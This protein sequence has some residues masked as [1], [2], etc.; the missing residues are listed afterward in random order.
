MLLMICRPVVFARQSTADRQGKH[1]LTFSHLIR[2]QMT[3]NPEG[4]RIKTTRQVFDIVEVLKESGGLGV[5]E[6]ARELNMSK[7]NAHRHLTTLDEVGYVVCE[8]GLYHPSARFLDIG[9]YVRYRNP[10][11]ELVQPKVE[12]LAEKTQERAEFI[13]EEHGRGVFL[14]RSTGANA[15]GTNTR[16]GATLPL[17]ASAAG[18]A[19]LSFLPEERLDEIIKQQGLQEQTPHTITDDETLREELE[20]IRETS[21]AY[22]D[23]ELI[24]G[25]RAVGTPICTPDG[26]VL[27]A[28]SITGPT[29]R[30]R[31]D[32]IESELPD[33]LRGVANEV[34]LNLAYS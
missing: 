22:N 2:P 14:H 28:L 34:E 15:V 27:G 16:I 1:S 18:K 6:V 7:S 29:C 10:V 32:T 13:V 3:T 8:D 4:G 30:F 25:L 31:D 26:D 12:Q 20:S 24:V 9:Q 11:S 33:L 23:Q 5:T 21:I 19:I 17:H